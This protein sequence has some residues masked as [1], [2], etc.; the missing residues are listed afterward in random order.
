MKKVF[1]SAITMILFH[2]PFSLGESFEDLKTQ[3]SQARHGDSQTLRRL[4]TAGNQLRCRNW[5][6]PDLKW[7]EPLQKDFFGADPKPRDFSISAEYGIPT[8]DGDLLALDEFGHLVR[9]EPPIRRRMGPFL[10]IDYFRES[11]QGILI[12]HRK[13]TFFSSEPLERPVQSYSICDLPPLRE[14]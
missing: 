10:L 12:E 3:Y 1:L 4:L 2:S 8:I 13:R 9:I 7:P 5:T 6:D 11:A 14:R